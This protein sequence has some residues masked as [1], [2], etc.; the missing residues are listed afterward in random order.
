M[1]LSVQ[2]HPLP[3]SPRRRW[4]QLGGNQAHGCLLLALMADGLSAA[5]IR[6]AFAQPAQHIE[7]LASRRLQRTGR[8]PDAQH[9]IGLRLL[10]GED[11]APLAIAS[12]GN[13]DVARLQL[14]ALHQFAALLVGEGE[15]VEVPSD[16]IIGDMHAPI[17]AAAAA[18][19]EARG[20]DE[21]DAAGARE[22]ARHRPRGSGDELGE[23]PEQPAI[24]G[25]Q[26]VTPSGV[27]DISKPEQDR[28]GA[29]GTEGAGAEDVGKQGAEQVEGRSNAADA[30]EG[31]EVGGLEG[32]G[33]RQGGNDIASPGIIEPGRRLCRL[34]RVGM[35]ETV[36]RCV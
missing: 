13:R 36:K 26:T 28:P 35:I 20:I 30:G 29:K 17:V 3:R 23:Q 1:M 33:G 11:T 27:R 6:S 19:R 9:N 21:P 4:A 8:R 25:A 32:E 2:P 34:R 12:V 16:Q 5:H 22:G 31:F 15:L 18:L 10:R 7:R 24:G 14:G